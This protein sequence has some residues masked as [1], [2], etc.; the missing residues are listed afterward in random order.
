MLTDYVTFLRSGL[1]CKCGVRCPQPVRHGH[2]VQVDIRKPAVAAVPAAS[3]VI[4]LDADANSSKPSTN[5]KKPKAGPSGGKAVVEIDLTEDDDV[6]A[7]TGSSGAG[8]DV[9]GATTVAVDNSAAASSA[10]MA[11]GAAASKVEHIIEIDDDDIISSYFGPVVKAPRV[12]CPSCAAA[13]CAACGESVDATTDNTGVQHANVCS[14]RFVHAVACAVERLRRVHLEIGNFI[15]TEQQQ[16]VNEVLGAKTRANAAATRGGIA[17]RGRG[18]KAAAAAPAPVAAAITSLAAGAAGWE[19]VDAAMME[20]ISAAEKKSREGAG[21]SSAAG[22][23]EQWAKYE[24]YPSSIHKLTHLTSTGQ[25]KVKK[26]LSSG[27]TLVEVAPSAMADVAALAKAG[28]AHPYTAKPSKKSSGYNPSVGYY[29]YGAYEDASDEDDDSD[30]YSEGG[31]LMSG[32]GGLSASS[33]AY[34]SGSHAGTGYAGS[35]SDAAV[36]KQHQELVRKRRQ[37]HD[38][39]LTDAIND[40]INVLPRNILDATRGPTGSDL[41]SDHALLLQVLIGPGCFDGMHILVPT[42]PSAATPAAAS[43][44]APAAAAAEPAAVA[45]APA[46]AKPVAAGGGARGRKRGAAAAGLDDTADT[47]P[48]A[49]SPPARATGGRAKRGKTATAAGAASAAASSSSIAPAPAPLVED[50]SDVEMIGTGSSSSSSSASAAV[51]KQSQ[52]TGVIDEAAFSFPGTD[53]RIG[54]GDGVRGGSALYVILSDLLRTSMM[55]IAS[56]DARRQLFF[57]VLKLV[58]TVSGH[59]DLA[60][61]LLFTPRDEGKRPG[62]S[63]T[64][65][66]ASASSGAAPS[67]SNGSSSKKNLMPGGSPARSLSKPAVTPGAAAAGGAA[68]PS[69]PLPAPL[70]PLTSTDQPYEAWCF[71][72]GWYMLSLFFHSMSRRHHC[73]ALVNAIA[74]QSCR[75]VRS[76]TRL[77]PCNHPV[78]YDLQASGP[79]TSRRPCCRR[80]RASCTCC[81]SSTARPSCSR[82]GPRARMMCWLDTVRQ[83]A[84]TR[85]ACQSS[86][87]LPSS[88]ATPTLSAC[89]TFPC[90]RLSLLSC[91]RTRSGNDDKE[92]D[93]VLGLALEVEVANDRVKSCVDKWATRYKQSCEVMGVEVEDAA[94]EDEEEQAEEGAGA[95]AS[96]SSAAASSSA[97]AASKPAP[98][99]KGRSKKAVAAAGA[100]AGAGAASSSS[101][102]AVAVALKDPAAECTPPAGQ[103]KIGWKVPAQLERLVD[104]GTDYACVALWRRRGDSLLS[105]SPCCDCGFTHVTTDSSPCVFHN[106]N[107]RHAMLHAGSTKR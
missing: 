55:D 93:A 52:A 63:P 100:G 62:P 76:V 86:L 70:M 53:K 9:S 101:S 75:C 44:T 67:A 22:A 78:N 35:A 58:T 36:M 71:P 83:P 59:P 26:P 3:A 41:A 19:S 33:S 38:V 18:G 49:A 80:H 1:K 81:K 84:C 23:G 31:D 73:H 64:S 14:M 6:P 40:L 105:C 89:F 69:T 95:G 103:S 37:A 13:I 99:G 46:P 8:S 48:S 92:Y 74:D 20:K 39:A 10:S 11:A 68:G 57:S 17:G 87:L 25:V 15:T 16:A 12:A 97:G 65:A 4:E 32:Y 98:K 45:P 29:P 54:W 21:A 50:V 43:A 61:A 30:S 34:K 77:E 51:A 96:S 88:H 102:S 28:Y 60:C 104:W 27:W 24:V 82:S 66:S 107:A 56:D 106:L 5:A 90:S 47:V 2:R 7:K 72:A 91:L 79:T 42:T 94:A 85:L